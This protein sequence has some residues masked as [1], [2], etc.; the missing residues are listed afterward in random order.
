MKE[1]GRAEAAAS[2]YDEVFRSG[3]HYQT[4]DFRS[5]KGYRWWKRFA[6]RFAGCSGVV[7]IGCGPGH[8]ARFLYSLGVPRYYGIDFSRVAIDRARAWAGNVGLDSAEY[9]FDCADINEAGDWDPSNEMPAGFIF[10]S[11][12]VLEHLEDDTGL[13]AKLPPGARF[14]GLVPS[15]DS[16]SHVRFFERPSDVR[17]RYGHLFDPGLTVTTFRDKSSRVYVFDGVLHKTR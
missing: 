15:I 16:L 5:F 9:M 10:T 7:D 12:A 2:Y 3:K 13:L 14:I 1:T 17:S 6:D 8:F 4:E 11:M